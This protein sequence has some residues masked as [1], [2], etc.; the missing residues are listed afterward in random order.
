MQEDNKYSSA[1]KTDSN[2]CVRLIPTT[3]SNSLQNADTLTCSPQA[4]TCIITQ[5]AIIV[6]S[7]L[8]LHFKVDCRYFLL[9]AF[10]CSSE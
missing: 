9:A 3:P 10:L 4:L 7:S 6:L 5:S 1:H 2:K 8:H